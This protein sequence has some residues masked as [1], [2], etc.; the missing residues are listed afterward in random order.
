MK[1]LVLADINKNRLAE[2]F[3]E[4]DF[5]Y[6]GYAIN[7]IVMDRIEL[8]EII[9]QY[10]ILISE[11]DTVDKEIIDV[12]TNLKLIICCRGGVSTVIDVPYAEKKGI[13]V[14]NTPGRNADAVAEYVIGQIIYN[15]RFLSITNEL[16]HKDVLQNNR[17][18]KPSEYG[19]SLWGMDDASPY[20]VY[21]GKGLKNIKLGIVGYGIV[22]SEVAKYAVNMGMKVMAYDHSPK[23][24]IEEVK[25][26]DFETLLKTAD[27]VSVHCSNK[28]HKVLFSKNEFSLMRH[29]SIFINTAR[30]DLVDEDALIHSIHIGHISKAILDVTRQEPLPIKHKLIAE[31]NIILTPH[32]AGATDRVID[33]GT[34]MVIEHMKNFLKR[35]F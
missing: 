8:K 2:E 22:G 18:I 21:R 6:K 27:I 19:D 33:Y 14:V 24:M 35:S 11:F 7:N 23:K 13:I 34:E 16:I 30:G 29:G 10:D 4:I 3:S 1:A 28:N 20:H 32:I 26:T 25:K 31:P 17:Y 12:A 15:D 9:V 5:D